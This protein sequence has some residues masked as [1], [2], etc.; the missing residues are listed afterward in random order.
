MK[1]TLHHI[2]L[3]ILATSS[4][5]AQPALFNQD[6]V[7][8]SQISAFE[9]INSEHL[10][11]SP[12]FYGQGIVYIG[13]KEKG[14]VY[15]EEINEAYFELKYFPFKSESASVSNFSPALN[16]DDVHKGPSSFSQ[17]DRIIYYTKER[18][19]KDGRDAVL[20]ILK[21]YKDEGDW[22]PDGEFPFNSDDFSNM[23]PA[24]SPDGSYMV[25]SSNREGGIG[26]Y[27]LYISKYE[28]GYWKKPEN[29]GSAVNSFGDESFPY[30][31]E[32]GSLLF[33][34]DG[35]GGFGKLDL[36]VSGIG[37]DNIWHLAENIG[38]PFN[39]KADDF[40]ITISEDGKSGFFTSNRKGGKG[41]DDIYQFEALENI[42]NV[43]KKEVEVTT[44][45]FQFSTVT[46]DKESKE[47]IQDVEVYAIPI[48]NNGSDFILSNFDIKAIDVVSE[49]EEIVMNL[50]PKEGALAKFL[51]ISDDN[52]KSNFLLDRN[53]RYFIF[54]Q[55][56]GYIS[57][58][59]AIDAVNIVPEITLLLNKEKPKVIA[60]TP[61]R[62]YK[63]E[64]YTLEQ[65][66]DRRELVVFNEIYYD[67]NSANLKAGATKE[68]DLLADYLIKNPQL[69]VELSSYTDARGER[70][71]NQSLSQR[72]AQSAKSYLVRRGLSDFRIVATGRGENNI[73]NH[74]SNGVTCSDIEHQYNRRTEVKILD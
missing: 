67:Y 50:K 28:N 22:I 35:R 38:A 62:T 31:H 29:L 1:R 60:P 40:G 59:T 32:D 24:V 19:F 73:R 30:I 15:D 52:G 41:K 57:S 49:D 21:A 48:I 45:N 37:E 69:R 61:V 68:L 72:R 10:D 6:A 4:L 51:N 9:S 26:G 71:Y 36:F 46:L 65:A 53:S 64:P 7:R 34:S 20:K 54:A 56:G 44:E 23:H 16:V 3:L 12:V 8:N 2:F 39:G 43:V 55:K 25:F 63:P 42:F 27:D 66:L 70:S 58:Q 17:Q 74:C 11:F 5:L 47:P 18:R 14:Q 33:A 13:N